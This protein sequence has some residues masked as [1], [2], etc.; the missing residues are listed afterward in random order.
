[1]GVLMRS[2]NDIEIRCDHCRANRLRKKPPKRALDDLFVEIIG[3]RDGRITHES[4]NSATA[5]GLRHPEI[6]ACP[7]RQVP[8]GILLPVVRH[9]ACK[10]IGKA[11]QVRDRSMSGS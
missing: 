4:T 5:A 8:T 2:A 6:P 1:M 3:S 10:D 11:L 9:T 7:S